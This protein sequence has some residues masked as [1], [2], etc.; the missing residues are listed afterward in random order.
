MGRC[1]R[2]HAPGHTGT[3][4]RA[5]CERH[6]R[7][8]AAWLTSR[9]TTAP[10]EGPSN[11]QNMR[12]CGAAPEQDGGVLDKSLQAVVRSAG[13]LQACQPQR[14]QLPLLKSPARQAVSPHA[15]RQQHGRSA[16]KA[17]WGLRGPKTS[18]AHL[19]Q[20]HHDSV[21]PQPEAE[22]HV[23]AAR[24]DAHLRRQERRGGSAGRPRRGLRREAGGC[25]A[26]AGAGEEGPAQHCT[27]FP[28]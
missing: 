23:P 14:L 10:L 24:H 20:P 13:V 16:D 15:P 21:H 28:S 19:S 25:G 1:R 12:V 27:P 17:G 7:R 4:Q 8:A 2:T 5:G 6:Q 18:T 11:W 3:A 22:Q 9:S 26:A